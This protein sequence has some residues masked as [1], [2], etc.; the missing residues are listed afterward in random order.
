MFVVPLL[1]VTLTLISACGEGGDPPATDPTAAAAGMDTNR[2]LAHVEELA[3]DAYEGRLTG[4]PAAERTRRF[5]T[6]HLEES[7]A[8]P[9]VAA[10]PQ[11]DSLSAWEHMA[12]A[13]EDSDAQLVNVVAVVPGRSVGERAAD[14][15]SP[16][17][18]IVVSAH[19]DHLGVRGGTIYNGAD[20]NASGTALLLELARYV[21]AN[22]VRH[23]VVFAFFDYEEG[24]LRGSRAF[25]GAPCGSGEIV[26]NINLDMVSRS[27]DGV[28]YAA[29]TRHWPELRPVLESV[30]VP[31]GMRLAFG[32]D[33]PGTGS[34]DWTLAS[35][36]APFHRAGIPFV[37]FGVEDHAGYHEPTDDFENIT[38]AFYRAV[39]A[40]I[41][42]V[43][44]AFD[45]AE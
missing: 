31:A 21:A 4:T 32:H 42:R 14:S 29:G 16:A 6:R 12:P 43:L 7:G 10:R 23:T 33:E 19:Y 41:P 15:R 9:C 39:G 1:F 3:S 17:A 11:P 35:D 40:F 37:Y 18:R 44:E 24:G 34:D 25:V 26:L 2:M 5:L 36:H 38:P 22:P 27:E 28:L 30:E 13:S 8:V 45:A 20:D